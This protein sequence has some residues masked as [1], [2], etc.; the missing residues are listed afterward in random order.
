MPV[1]DYACRACGYR[2]DALVR[3]SEGPA[4][5]ACASQELERLLSF[6]AIKSES[7]HMLAMAAAKR[8]DKKQAREGTRKHQEHEAEHVWEST[9]VWPQIP[10][11]PKTSD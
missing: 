2:F 7:T 5:P 3:G 1:Y 11:L 6:P 9:G 4:C 8:R 10:D